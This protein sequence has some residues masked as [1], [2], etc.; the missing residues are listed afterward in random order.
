[1]RHSAV[2]INGVAVIVT[3]R[4]GAPALANLINEVWSAAVAGAV[5]CADF[6]GD[7]AASSF[8]SVRRMTA[9][10]GRMT[11]ALEPSR[12]CVYCS[13]DGPCVR[14]Q[15]SQTAGDRGG[16]ARG[17]AVSERHQDLFQSM[18]SPGRA[19]KRSNYARRAGASRPPRAPRAPRA[20]E[21]DHI[22]IYLLL[23]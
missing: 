17:V 13:A 16:A 15:D 1:M 10:S 11:V 5:L 19:D 12:A 2:V 3:I 20:A 18:N 7:A 6:G 23:C 22:T 4:R 14:R 8:L 9:R 21:P